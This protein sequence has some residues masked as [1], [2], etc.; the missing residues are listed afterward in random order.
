MNRSYLCPKCNGQ[1][2]AGDHITFVARTAGGTTGLLLLSPEL[3]DYHP[4]HH[5]SFQYSEGDRI[6][7]LCPLCHANLSASELHQNLAR[8]VMI[9]ED[10]RRYDIVFSEIAG[11]KCTYKIGNEEIESFGEDSGH[12]TNFFGERRWRRP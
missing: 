2:K 11:E 1:L 7:F 10:D 9:D 4:I 3:G 5:P 8:I 6:E 12:Y